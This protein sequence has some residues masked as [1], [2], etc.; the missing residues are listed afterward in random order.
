MTPSTPT[1]PTPNLPAIPLTPDLRAAY[2]DL[3]SK[4]ETAIENT[5]DPGA[6]VTLMASQLDVQNILTKDDMYRLQA[7]TALYTA[8]L[9]QITTTNTNLASLKTQIESITSHISTFGDILA[10]I[11]KVLTLVPAL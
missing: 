2:A 4:Y 7:N 3:Y 9:H 8:L 6:K 11:T 10:A 1:P 5:R